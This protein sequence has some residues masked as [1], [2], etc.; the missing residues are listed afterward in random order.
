M[1]RLLGNFL[2]ITT[3]VWTN[4]V[5]A[6]AGDP[7]AHSDPAGGAHAHHAMAAQAPCQHQDCEGCPAAS[8]A[9]IIEHKLVTST[10]TMFDGDDPDD[11]LLCFAT[12]ETPI[13]SATSDP[14]WHQG[15]VQA[16]DTPITLHDILL[17]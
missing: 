11:T 2:L 10:R 14:P 5:C 17:E 15:L 13:R 4:V 12:A 16:P 3:L 9:Q 6:C 1:A 8:S 7:P